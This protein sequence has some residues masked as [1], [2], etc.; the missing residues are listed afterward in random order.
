[1][2]GKREQVREFLR[3]EISEGLQVAVVEMGDRGA[4]EVIR[5]QIGT[6]SNQISWRFYNEY[7][8]LELADIMEWKRTRVR[9]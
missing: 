5:T 3:R 9:R 1:M 8:F 7:R 6:L 2:Q 4:A